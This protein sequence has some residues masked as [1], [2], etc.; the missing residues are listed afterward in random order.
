MKGH[1][2]HDIIQEDINTMLSWAEKWQLEFHPDKCVS[3]AINRRT[4]TKEI[5]RMHNTELRQA[6]QEKDIG[7]I[8]DSN[9]RTTCRRKSKR[10]TT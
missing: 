6:N 7:V 3:M 5:Y 1:D 8:I 2:D 9:L 10:Q 4:K